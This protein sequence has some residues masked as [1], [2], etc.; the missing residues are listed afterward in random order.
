M[1]ALAFTIPATV[2][3]PVAAAARVQLLFKTT[4]SVAVVDDAEATA[5]PVPAKPERIVTVGDAGTVKLEGHTAVIVFPVTAEMA[6]D[7]V[8]PSVHVEVAP[9]WSEPGTKV[10]V[11]G[12]ATVAMVI[13]DVV[14]KEKLRSVSIVNPAVELCVV[15]EV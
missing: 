4:V 1:P 14:F 5:Q 3:V 6:F 8:I 15:L 11:V 10:T 7:S 9:A 2:N 12:V 13:V